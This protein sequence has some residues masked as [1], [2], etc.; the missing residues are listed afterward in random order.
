MD[1]LCAPAPGSNVSHTMY[2]G[3]L[4]GEGAAAK[5]IQWQSAH[6]VDPRTGMRPIEC[7]WQFPVGSNYTGKQP[8]GINE[9][10]VAH[11]KWCINVCIWESGSTISGACFTAA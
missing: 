3:A 4:C 7:T 6:T 2:K 9:C 11:D 8:F 10:V 1:Q 5:H